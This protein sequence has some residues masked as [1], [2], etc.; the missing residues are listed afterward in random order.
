VKY[1]Y[2]EPRWNDIDRVKLLIIPPEV[3]GNPAVLLDD[4][5]GRISRDL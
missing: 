5:V 3:S 1:A 4:S 2:E